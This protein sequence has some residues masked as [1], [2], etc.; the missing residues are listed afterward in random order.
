[1]TSEDFIGKRF[2]KIVVKS[3]DRTKKSKNTYYICECDCGNITSVSRPNLRNHTRSCGC[4]SKETHT[5][6]GLSK[7][8]IAG[9]YRSMLHR[10]NSPND[11]A[12]KD[13]GGRGI[14]VCEEWNNDILA[15]YKW[16]MDNGYQDDLTLD[17]IN[18]N[19]NY[20]PSNCR[21]TDRK[22]QSNNTRFNNH[23]LYNG[24][25][26]TLSELSRELGVSIN[27]IYRYFATERKVKTDNL[28]I[29]GTRKKYIPHKKQA[30]I[31]QAVKG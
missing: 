31:I 3:I 1:M 8:R 23:V 29:T 19:G 28:F 11:H 13:Y 18:V 17:R 25:T 9:I 14:K 6:H 2:G 16:A 5:K 20:E 24:E 10:C 12:Y 7:T 22:T 15:F 21:W 27:T 30:D 26:Y 4:L